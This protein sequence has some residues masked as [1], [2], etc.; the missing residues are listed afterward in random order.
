MS[1]DYTLMAFAYNRIT[2]PVTDAGLTVNDS[3]AFFN[4]DTV[5]DTSSAIL[6]AI[7]FTPLFLTAQVLVWITPLAETVR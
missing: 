1:G 3:W 5:D 2:F 6:F 7:T 4:A